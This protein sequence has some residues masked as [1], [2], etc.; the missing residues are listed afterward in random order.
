MLCLFS[1]W[2]VL[3]SSDDELFEMDVS[4]NLLFTYDQWMESSAPFVR[5]Q[6]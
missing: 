2:N 4:I 5:L 1:I 6:L 3:L